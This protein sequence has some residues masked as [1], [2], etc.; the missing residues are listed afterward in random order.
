MATIA[1][2]STIVKLK[3]RITVVLASA[4]VG[5]EFKYDLF[6]LKILVV[7]HAMQDIK[8]KYITQPTYPKGHN[9]ERITTRNLIRKNQII[10][11][12]E[13]KVEK[14]QPAHKSWSRLTPT[15]QSS[16]NISSLSS[17]SVHR[18]IIHLTNFSS[19]FG[20]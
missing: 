15:S 3:P 20:N 10:K 18:S 17:L 4:K 19:S 11:H 14:K 16:F 2:A 5:T 7:C 12:T 13:A 1:L 9:C 8:S 6:P